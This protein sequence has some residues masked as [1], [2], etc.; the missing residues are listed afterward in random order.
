MDRV[1]VVEIPDFVRVENLVPVGVSKRAENARSHHKAIE[2]KSFN[3]LVHQARAYFTPNELLRL[4]GAADTPRIFHRR[5]AT[6]S[7]NDAT[8]DELLAASCLGG[9]YISVWEIERSQANHVRVR[10]PAAFLQEQF[11]PEEIRKRREAL[12][13]FILKDHRGGKYLVAIPY[14]NTCRHVRYVIVDV[15]VVLMS[16]AQKRGDRELLHD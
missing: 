8:V 12:M 1:G 10:P 4:L 15:E 5:A 6:R 3:G 11:V 2:P 14:R 16:V 13:L 9:E 7:L